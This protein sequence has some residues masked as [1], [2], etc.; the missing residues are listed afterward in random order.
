MVV[1]TVFMTIITILFARSLATF[2]FPLLR[3]TLCA[4]VVATNAV[5]I[6]N[7]C[8]ML[9]TLLTLQ[10]QMIRMMQLNFCETLDEQQLAGIQEKIIA[11]WKLMFLWM[12]G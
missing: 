9:V 10:K 1:F 8:V 12:F 7:F 6:Q 3:S 11:H 5:T 2:P 4:F